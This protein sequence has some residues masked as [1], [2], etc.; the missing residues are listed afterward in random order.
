MAVILLP[1]KWLIRPPGRPR[2]NL[3]H[4]LARGL[5]CFIDFR[6]TTYRFNLVTGKDLAPTVNSATWTEAGVITNGSTAT[7]TYSDIG[8]AAAA[9]CSLIW[10]HKQ[11][12]G[13]VSWSLMSGSWNGYYS[14]DTNDMHIA[15]T[16]SFPG[17]LTMNAAVTNGFQQ[18][19]KAVRING[20]NDVTGMAG[21][22]AFDTDSSTGIPTGAISNLKIGTDFD[23]G[24]PAVSW[25]EYWGIYDRPLLDVELKEMSLYPWQIMEAPAKTY[26]LNSAAAAGGGLFVNPL[27][28][29]GGGAAMPI[30]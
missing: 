27:T 3:G 24:N 2:V 7:L 4:P 22:G 23:G 26:F 18:S 25:I 29:I 9:P 1:S 12:S 5:K 8:Y 21:G 6:S 20:T 17:Q 14:Q 15:V 10:S 11:V 30:A 13:T 16:V 28:G 19:R